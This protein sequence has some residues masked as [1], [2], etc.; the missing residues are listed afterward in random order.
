M[1]ERPE[2]GVQEFRET[3]RTRID[4]AWADGETT[5]VTRHGQTVAALVPYKW[6]QQAE[7]LMAEAGHDGPDPT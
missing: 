1:T 5:L 3:L 6:F 2:M 7:R 4:A